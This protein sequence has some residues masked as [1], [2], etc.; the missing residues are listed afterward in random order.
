MSDPQHE[1]PKS[2]G[3]DQPAASIEQGLVKAFKQSVTLRDRDPRRRRN[4]PVV[5]VWKQVVFLGFD[6]IPVDKPTPKP[7][8]YWLDIIKHWYNYIG[9]SRLADWKRLC[10]NLYL[11]GEFKTKKDCKKALLTVWV[12]LVD[13]LYTPKHVALFGS[14]IDLKLYVRY[15]PKD[16]KVFPK[17]LIKEMEDSPLEALLAYVIQKRPGTEGDEVI[18]MLD[19]HTFRPWPLEDEHWIVKSYEFAGKKSAKQGN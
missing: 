15:N 3:S 14:E 17:F 8:S 4:E 18:K 2:E 11:E 16:R 13:F 1:Q 7:E 5:H 9:H 19:K 12:N 6:G 10:S